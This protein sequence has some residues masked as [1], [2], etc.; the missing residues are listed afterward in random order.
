MS[1]LIG[2]KILLLYARFFEYDTIVKSK[3]Q[4]LGAVVDLYDARANINS[5]GKAL[6]KKTDKFYKKKQLRFHK[7]ICQKRKTIDYD[8]I[9][10]NENLSFEVLKGYRETFPNAKLVLYLDDSVENLRN[11][12]TTFS[13]YDKVLS[14]DRFDSQKYN[15][16]FRP[17]FFNDVI[18]GYK[19]KDS[20]IENDICFVGT[21]HSDRLKII[22]LLIEAYP[23]RKFNLYIYLQS[24]FMY[25]Y[26]RLKN[27]DY[28]GHKFSFF[29]YKKITMPEVASLMS[30]SKT[31][32]DI[33]HPKQSGLTMRTI[34][35]IGMG[36]KLI[37]TNQDIVNYDFYNPGNILIIDRDNPSIN[38]SFFEQQYL[39]LD[40]K[41]YQKYSIDSWVKDVFG[42]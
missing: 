34:E 40:M 22:N 35:T 30:K 29:K 9:F 12:N 39:E 8:F 10:T 25:F 16:L 21:A 38:E 28:R 15:I 32:L 1:F 27:K 3:L 6:L 31:I 42:D 33:Q 37:T 13:C 23:Q 26:Y 36:K 14:F 5:I 4:E 24:W 20:I 11:V 19:S 2:K 7:K 17:L 18:K 41:I